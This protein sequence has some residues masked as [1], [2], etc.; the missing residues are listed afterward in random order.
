MS[1]IVK[2]QSRFEAKNMINAM[3]IGMIV[4][5]T[6][7]LLLTGR[8]EEYT[9]IVFSGVDSAVRLC[10]T[11]FGLMTFWGGF[12]EIANQS[13]VTKMFSKV[14]SPVVSRLFPDVQ[15]GSDAQK[16]ISMNITANMLGLGNAATPIGLNAMR[17]LYILGGNRPAATD[18]MVTFVVLNTASVQLV[19]VTVAALRAKYGSVSP[20]QV[21]PAVLATSAAALIVGLTAERL[22]RRKVPKP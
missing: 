16:S 20:M 9:E 7:C 22:F 18:S 10:I 12:M 19:P 14:M 2:K 13:G 17:Q 15:K 6:A 21:L 3:W 4:A 11:M 8:A 5:S 1:Q